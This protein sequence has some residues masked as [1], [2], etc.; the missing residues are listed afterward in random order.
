MLNIRATLAPYWHP[1]R[2]VWYP[3]GSWAEKDEAGHISRRRGFKG[4]G[5]DSRTACQADCDRLN[6]ALEAAVT[7]GPRVASFTEAALVYLQ[8]GGEARFLHD[9]LLDQ[10][11]HLPCDLIDDAVMTAAA[12]AIYPGCTPATVNR[13]LYTPVIRVLNLAAKGR[14]W[15]PHDLERPK[16]YAKLRPARS[17]DKG[18]FERVLPVCRPALKALL[19]FVTLHGRRAGEAIRLKPTDLDPARGAVLIQEDKSGNPVYVRLADPVMAAIDEYPWRLGP[20]LFGSYTPRN[21]RNLFRDLEAACKKAGVEYFTPHKAG[22]HAFAKRLLNEGRSLAHVQAAGKW[23]TIRVVAELYSAF[24]SDEVDDD[25]RKIGADWAKGLGTP[26]PG[27]NV[28]E[29]KK[30]G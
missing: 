24:A 22:R 3:R 4:A 27:D 29:L 16:G 9:K 10:I 23:A 26:Q 17:P 12:R 19:L 6:I 15:K 14:E 18:W 28:V 25:V 2:R 11:G 8:T 5:S 20:G 30:L 7:A 13:Q 21:R 1:K